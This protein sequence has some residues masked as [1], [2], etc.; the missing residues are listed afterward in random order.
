MVVWTWLEKGPQGTCWPSGQPGSTGH[1]AL[2]KDAHCLRCRGRPASGMH[3]GGR[4]RDRSGRQNRLSFGS[5]RLWRKLPCVCHTPGTRAGAYMHPIRVVSPKRRPAMLTHRR[6]GA[7]RLQLWGGASGFCFGLNTSFWPWKLMEA[8]H[9]CPAA[10]PSTV[11][12]L[13]SFIK[14]GVVAS[15]YN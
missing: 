6:K 12:R 14:I 10:L 4:K 11:W 8:A 1:R 9:R 13:V 2:A 7:E 3:T 15:S 5:C